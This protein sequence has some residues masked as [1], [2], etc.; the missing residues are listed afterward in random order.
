MYI[1]ITI[2]SILFNYFFI[3]FDQYLEQNFTKH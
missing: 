2:D 1:K 3:L